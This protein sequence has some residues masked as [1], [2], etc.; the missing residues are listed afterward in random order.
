[1]VRDG[2]DAL[3]H[4][5]IEE[6]SP[7]CGRSLDPE[8]QHEERGHQRATPDARQSDQ[9]ADEEARKDKERRR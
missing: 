5:G 2:T 8:N 4:R 6:V 1:M 9:K 3:G 7:D